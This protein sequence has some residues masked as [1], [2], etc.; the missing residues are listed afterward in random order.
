[1]AYWLMNLNQP[2]GIF[3]TDHFP[4]VLCIFKLL[5]I[6]VYITIFQNVRISQ[7]FRTVIGIINCIG[8]IVKLC[9][10]VNLAYLLHGTMASPEKS[11]SQTSLYQFGQI[12]PY[13][14]TN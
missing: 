13:S 7:V 14:I 6:I 8:I 9:F 11:I 3:F 2:F 12:Y 4:T 1:M 10:G 5:I